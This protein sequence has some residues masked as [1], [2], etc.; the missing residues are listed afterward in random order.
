MARPNFTSLQ[1]KAQGEVVIDMFA[2]LGYFSIPLS[3]AD[4]VCLHV[5]GLVVLMQ[6]TLHA[7]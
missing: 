2:G 5:H 1:V 7:G 6:T 3:M 4:G